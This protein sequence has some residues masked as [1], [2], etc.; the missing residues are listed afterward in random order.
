MKSLRGEIHWPEN[1]IVKIRLDPREEVVSTL[2]HEFLH[3][4]HPVWSETD[5]LKME[6]SLMNAL[7]PRQVKTIIRK[8]AES[9]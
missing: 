3:H 6:V 1:G 7:S 9:I 8:L 4:I 2:I 5:I